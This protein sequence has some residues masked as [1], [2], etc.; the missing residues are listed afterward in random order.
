MKE[1]SRKPD[2]ENHKIP[3]QTALFKLAQVVE[4]PTNLAVGLLPS[5]YKAEPS[6]VLTITF[7]KKLPRDETGDHS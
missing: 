5:G 7:T 1:S 3:T 6:E 2:S 4:K